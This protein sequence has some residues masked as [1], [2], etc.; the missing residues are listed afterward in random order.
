MQVIAEACG[1]ATEWI[2]RHPVGPLPARD[3]VLSSDDDNNITLDVIA[4]RASQVAEDSDSDEN[5]PLS[6]VAS[7]ARRH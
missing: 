5:R 3:E 6:E 4:G 7:Q 2:A 1:G